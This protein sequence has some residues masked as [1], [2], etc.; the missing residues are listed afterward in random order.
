MSLPSQ[1]KYAR[2][3]NSGR[4]EVASVQVEI[5]PAQKLF[6][7]VNPFSST[8]LS[9]FSTNPTV[10]YLPLVIFAYEGAKGWGLNPN[11]PVKYSLFVNIYKSI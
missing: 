1:K 4:G 6:L 10:F 8:I 7:A 9:L 5:S 3:L 2:L 11:S